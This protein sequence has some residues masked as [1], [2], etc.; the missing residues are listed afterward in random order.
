MNL[1]SAK[2]LCVRGPHSL[3][4]CSN[5]RRSKPRRR[6]QV[7]VEFSVV[8]IVFV[9]VFMAMIEI[10][11]SMNL[12]VTLNAIVYATAGRA[13]IKDDPLLIYRKVDVAKDL[14]AEFLKYKY[15]DFSHAE[16]DIDLNHVEKSPSG[17]EVFFTKVFVKYSMGPLFIPGLNW[18]VTVTAHR[19]N[20]MQ[21]YRPP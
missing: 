17:T 15:L 18:D 19:M 12:L 11:R 13:A 20:Q 6:G 7:L 3:S 4:A 14:E 16:V 1:G 9:T 10:A 5:S 21:G 2:L 8:F